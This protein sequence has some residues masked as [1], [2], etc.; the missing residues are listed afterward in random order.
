M[1]PFIRGLSIFIVL[2][3]LFVM[4][5]PGAYALNDLDWQCVLNGKLNAIAYGKGIY[6]AV[7]QAGIIELSTD[8]THWKKAKS[9]ISTA[10]NG[11]FWSGKEFI[12]VG[13]YG[14][15]LSSKDG[16][17]W[18]KRNS[19]TKAS[20]RKAA[21][22][23]MQYAAVGDNGT[24]LFS[25]D[26]VKWSKVR[27]GTS[28]SLNGIAVNDKLFVAVGDNSTIIS[29]KDGIAWKA[30][31]HIADNNLPVS[32]LKDIIWINNT[33]NIVGYTKGKVYPVSILS[34]DAGAWSAEVISAVEMK[35]LSDI[36]LYGAAWDGTQII[37]VGS[38][39]S[40][41]TLPECHQ[42]RKY[43]TISD[44]DLKGIASG[45]NK[46][47]STGDKGIFVSNLNTGIQS[48]TP[49]SVAGHV[50]AGAFLI[51]VRKPDE[52]SQKHIPGSINIPLD[53]LEKKIAGY[54]PDKQ[55]E[56]IVYCAKGV[57]S[58]QAAEILTKLGYKNVYNL[59]GID[60]WPY[61]TEP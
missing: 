56:I 5:P 59:G 34:P 26:G 58:R 52:Y 50:V 44:K 15:I 36:R 27:S 3:T 41:L 37:A 45:T 20:L 32:M 12:A 19:G 38:N 28:N 16:A 8:G 13:D 10:L 1:R 9:G 47:L 7:G 23:K 49:Y 24:V 61:A 42:C 43:K 40:I 17:V 54:V 53:G 57:R 6:A 25:K 22:R 48:I 2:I 18:Q 31:A 14:T 51:D 4:I 21:G 46:I 35:D 39:G 11:V 30:S 33:F 55:T 29:S 60:Q